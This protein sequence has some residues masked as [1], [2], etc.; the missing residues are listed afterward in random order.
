MWP[1]LLGVYR[2]DSTSDECQTQDED[3]RLQ[4]ER[5]TIQWRL[6]ASLALQREQE[7]APPEIPAPK[8]SPSESQDHATK[9]AFFRKDSSLSNDVFE[10]V[11]APGAGVN[12]ED[13][14]RPETVVEET[15]SVTSPTIEP[16]EGVEDLAT[17]AAEEHSQSV[18]CLPVN[19]GMR[20]SFDY[21]VLPSVLL[22]L[23]VGRQEGHPACTRWGDGG[24]GYWLVRMEWRPAGWSLCLPLLIFPCTI[25]SRSS[26]LAL[27]HPG[28]PRKR[29]I[30][31][32]WCGVWWF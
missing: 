10:S 31:R 19:T 7:T 6:A 12:G 3:A 26:P 32:L 1:Y 29:A 13:V 21:Q 24:G 28:G 11:D 9:M 4:Y 22:T 20:F 14:A 5:L 15:P 2:L 23:L 17:E 25:K 30:K 16:A 8:L 27:A 18:A